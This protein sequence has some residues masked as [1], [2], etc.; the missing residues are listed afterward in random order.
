M[1]SQKFVRTR[2]RHRLPRSGHRILADDSFGI[3]RSQYGSWIC[4]ASGP[5]ASLA[6]EFVAL[7]VWPQ[8]IQGFSIKGSDG[9]SITVDVTANNGLI[10]LARQSEP[11]H[12]VLSGIVATTYRPDGSLSLTELFVSP[13]PAVSQPA[14]AGPSPSPAPSVSLAETLRGTILKLPVFN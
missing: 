4:I 10:A 13:T 8:V 12:I 5:W 11:P 6:C 2:R 14:K 9:A 3:V 7:M 1:A